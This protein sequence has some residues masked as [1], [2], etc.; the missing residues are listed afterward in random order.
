MPAA[1]LRDRRFLSSSE[2]K[3]LLGYSEENSGEFL[4]MIRKE[5]VPFVKLNARRFIFDEA[6][7]AQW[8]DR[9]SYNKTA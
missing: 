7:L 4:Q 9:R 1:T 5:G 2:V 8:I 6:Q 3:K